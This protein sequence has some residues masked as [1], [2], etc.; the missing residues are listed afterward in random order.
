LMARPKRG[1][2]VPPPPVGDEWDLRYATKES[3]AFA[4]MERQ[5][6]GNAAEA[7]ARLRTAPTTR[8]DV[9]K[10]LRGS[11][12]T[13][14][15]GGV[16]MPQWQYDISSGARLWYCVDLDKRIVWLTLAAMGHPRATMA[17]GKRAPRN[18]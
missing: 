16:E 12:G 2:Q 5:F 13:R 8:S 1:Q 7:K 6:P 10:P 17:R 15:V 4:E 9:Q 18:R 11:L 14:N 3:L